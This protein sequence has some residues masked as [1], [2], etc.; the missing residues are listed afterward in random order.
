MRKWP[1]S[2][3]RSFKMFKFRGTLLD[4][5]F[6]GS[7]YVKMLIILHLAEKGLISISMIWLLNLIVVTGK[8]YNVQINIRWESVMQQVL[9]CFTLS[10]CKLVI[11]LSRVAKNNES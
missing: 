6:C 9:I 8:D 11:F 10:G 1:V 3:P 4:H 7:V 5:L 2:A